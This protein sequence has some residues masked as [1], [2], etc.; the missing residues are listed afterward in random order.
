MEAFAGAV[1]QFCKT[2]DAL[3]RFVDTLSPVLSSKRESFFEEHV[4]DLLPW[5]YTSALAGVPELQL[6]PE[7]M[8]WLAKRLEDKLTINEHTPDH[9][10]YVLDSDTAERM[11]KAFVEYEMRRAHLPL[12]CA[13]SLVTL[14]S[15]AEVLVSD[16]LHEIYSRHPSMAN[17]Q[18]KVLSMSEL[19]V[20]STIE[21]ARNHVIDGRIESILRQSIKAWLKELRKKLA[22]STDGDRCLKERL[23][24]AYLRRNLIVHHGGKVDTLYLR[25][26]SGKCI[27]GGVAIGD[28]LDVDQEYLQSAISNAEQVFALVGLE[29]SKKHD[30][31]DQTRGGLI[32]DRISEHMTREHWPL[33]ENYGFFLAEDIHLAGTTRLQ[34]EMNYW[35]ACK[36]QGRLDAVSCDIQ[37]KNLDGQDEIFSL[38]R[39]ALLD[40]YN[41]LL[42]KLPAAIEN[43]L[44]SI[45]Q[46][47]GQPVF[48]EVRATDRF[49]EEYARYLPPT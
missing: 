3:S 25:Q 47:M 40:E 28:H 35:L 29:A 13:S 43:R 15:V 31:D 1:Q 9:L 49:R 2:L 21:E 46:L 36:R 19:A 26:A 44:L 34:G 4:E 6:P 30:P 5:Y 24:E 18:Q 38:I 16:L 7:R 27:A 14:F 17:D 42:D 20:F 39:L 45:D 37:A 23:S 10:E 12:L 48:Q 33:V 22:L 11:K 32:M 8:D 41:Q